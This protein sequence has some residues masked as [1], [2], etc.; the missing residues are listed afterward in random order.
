MS[1]SKV[2]SATTAT[3]ERRRHAARFRQTE[4]TTLLA[5]AD[6]VAALIGAWGSPALWAAFDREYVPTAGQPVWQI[7][8]ALLWFLT[9]RAFG[10]ADLLRPRLGRR[11]IRAVSLTTA[12]MSAF[13][14]L[15]F[16]FLPFIAP[17]G[18]SLL[19]LPV[20]AVATLVFRFA[21]LRLVSS[22]LLDRRLAFFGTDE[23][24]RR[25]AAAVAEAHE[26]TPY[27]TMA[28]VDATPTAE[29]VLGA[30]VLP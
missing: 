30:P 22:P 20:T 2:V 23:G 26:S 7:A 17:R 13:V 29:R 3:Q 5:L 8:F 14:L 1:S 6:G 9:L 10:A 4:L 27:R 24:A 21:Y 12:T 16:Y 25:A 18:S 15:G 19:A 28:F 11:S